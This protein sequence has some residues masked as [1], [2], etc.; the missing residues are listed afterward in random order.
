MNK[1]IYIVS[2]LKNYEQ[3]MHLRDKLAE[4]GIWLTY[5]WAQGIHNNIQ[6]GVQEAETDLPAIA[7]AEY[8]AVRDAQL[9]FFVCP[10]GRGGHFELGV[11]YERG[12]PIVQLA[13]PSF[14]TAPIAF[15]TLPGIE[16]YKDERNA[17]ERILELV[18]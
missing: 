5:D 1:K 2:S 6:D 12:I 11:A 13:D 7:A 4:F 15:Y 18:G 17:I 16:R 3:V 8:Q 14:K 9:L 10:A